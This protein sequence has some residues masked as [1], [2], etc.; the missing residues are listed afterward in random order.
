MSLPV[1][2]NED[3]KKI[4][5]LIDDGCRVKDD[6]KALNEGLKETVAA[7]AEEMDIAPKVLNKAIMTVYK[8]SLHEQQAELDDIDELLE[9]AKRKT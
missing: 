6:V 1:L 7:I 3:V 5:T 9:I 8:E 4:K 2:S